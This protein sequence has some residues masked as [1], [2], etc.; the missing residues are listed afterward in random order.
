MKS[1]NPADG[2]RFSLSTTFSQADLDRFFASG[3]NIVLA[4]PTGGGSP[5]VAWIVYR[6]LVENNISW[7]EN[8]GIYA[9]NVEVVNGA[10]LSQMSQTP[11]PAESDVL[12]TMSPTGPITGPQTSG[13]TPNA[14]SII[15]LYSNLPK[16]Y[17]TFGLYQNA[18][19]NGDQKMGN[20]V[21][22]AAVLYNS[23]A[24]MTPYTTVYLWVQS[25]VVSNTVVTQVTSPM[26]QVKLGGDITTADLTYNPNTGTFVPSSTE[27]RLSMGR[28]LEHILPRL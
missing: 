25:Q 6:P 23:T 16:G 15:N 26:T 10:V 8:Y 14:Y 22:A 4:K 24:V 20:V 12:Y 7:E 21:S 18:T 1:S 11:F 2:V 17:L 27:K 13:G 28:G 5:N 19:V 9:S 3:S